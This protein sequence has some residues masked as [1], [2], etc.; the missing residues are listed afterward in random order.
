MNIFNEVKR[1]KF[2]HKNA[3][4]D[5]IIEE[6]SGNFHVN[7]WITLYGDILSQEHFDSND[8]FDTLEEAEKTGIQ[9]AIRW[10]DQQT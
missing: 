5:Y 9:T 6:N 4:I 1:G 10:I 7:V 8:T 2:R 3:D